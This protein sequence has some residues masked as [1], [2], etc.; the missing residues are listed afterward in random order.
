MTN[1]SNEVAWYPS[2]FGSYCLWFK[3]RLL[4]EVIEKKMRIIFWKGMGHTLLGVGIVWFSFG[5]HEDVMMLIIAGS[6]LIG[7][8]GTLCGGTE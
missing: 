4:H 5:A 7:I 2:S 6:A 3:S 1:R 8:G